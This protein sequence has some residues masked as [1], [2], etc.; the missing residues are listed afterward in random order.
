[1]SLV[2]DNYPNPADDLR[3]YHHLKQIIAQGCEHC[4]QG[5]EAECEMGADSVRYIHRIDGE[6]VQCEFKTAQHNL[7]KALEAVMHWTLP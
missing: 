5:S 7:P 1:M 3:Y 2:D 4:R 6:V